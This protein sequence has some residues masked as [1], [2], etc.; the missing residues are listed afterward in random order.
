MKR[1]SVHGRERCTRGWWTRRSCAA[2]TLQP[3]SGVAGSQRILLLYDKRSINATAARSTHAS[4]SAA[5][6][7]RCV[8]GML[9]SLEV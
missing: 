1:S 4:A 6:R 5:K 8:L 2:P 3:C 9:S 7:L